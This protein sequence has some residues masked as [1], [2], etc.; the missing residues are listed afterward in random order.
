MAHFKHGSLQVLAGDAVQ[1]GQRLAD[2]GNSGGSNEPH[3]HIY[4]QRPGPPDAPMG[5]EPLP[6]TF[7]GRFLVRGERIELT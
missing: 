5:G 4:A 2:V 1:V 7:D 3:L 6:I